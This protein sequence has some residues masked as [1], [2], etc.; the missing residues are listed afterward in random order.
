M[1]EFSTVL[2]SD[3]VNLRHISYKNLFRNWL[4]T[5][6]PP[7]SDFSVRSDAHKRTIMSSRRLLRSQLTKTKNNKMKNH[8]PKILTWKRKVLESISMPT[9][10]QIAHSRLGNAYQILNQ[11]T[12]LRL[13]RSRFF[14][15]ETLRG[16]LFAIHFSLDRRSIYCAPKSLVLLNRR[17]SSPLAHTHL[18]LKT[19]EKS[20]NLYQKKTA[21]LIQPQRLLRLPRPK[22]G[23]I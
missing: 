3:L 17:P 9:T 21:K 16:K 5:I 19:I 20:L 18:I 12:L 1:K 4:L 14:S 22:L 6:R 23:F 11:V 2:V 7:I 8:R 15:R 13:A 10:L